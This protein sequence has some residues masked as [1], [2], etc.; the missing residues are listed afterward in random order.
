[1]H[2]RLEIFELAVKGIDLLIN[3]FH[4]VILFDVLLLCPL[5]GQCSL[6]ENVLLLNAIQSNDHFLFSLLLTDHPFML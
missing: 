3:L 6:L 4:P 5:G 1:M 2:S